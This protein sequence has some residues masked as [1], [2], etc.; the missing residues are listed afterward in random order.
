MDSAQ[1][2]AQNIPRV[3]HF[4]SAEVPLWT[5]MAREMK[6]TQLTRDV[7]DY[8]REVKRLEDAGFKQARE[9]FWELSRGALWDHVIAEV[10]I[11]PDRKSLW[12]RLEKD[13]NARNPS[14]PG[15]LA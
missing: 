12:C 10:V 14:S 15:A 3:L 11:G 4:C 8:R 7:L 2:G 1:E 5:G 6:V 13:P 9:P